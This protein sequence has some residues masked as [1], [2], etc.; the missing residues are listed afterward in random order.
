MKLGGDYL[1]GASRPLVCN[2]RSIMAK[3][4]KSGARTKWK[5][6]GVANGKI[7]NVYK[8]FDYYFYE[9]KCSIK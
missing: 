8:N 4:C 3:R 5:E 1:F 2:D 7:M 6:L 9:Q